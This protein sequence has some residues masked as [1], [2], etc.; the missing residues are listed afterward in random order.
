MDESTYLIK[1]LCILEHMENFLHYDYKNNINNNNNNNNN[2]NKD[3]DNNNN[4]ETPKLDL[5]HETG[6][7]LK[8]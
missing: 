1:C 3:I 5:H 4:N 7:D 6:N 8:I 2:N